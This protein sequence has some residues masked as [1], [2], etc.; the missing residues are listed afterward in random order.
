MYFV[1]NC[2]LKMCQYRTD[3]EPWQLT[4]PCILYLE[5]EKVSINYVHQQQGSLSNK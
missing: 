2:S 1:V 4:V 3:K 5:T